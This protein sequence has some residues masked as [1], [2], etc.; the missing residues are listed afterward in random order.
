[1][2][3]R[4][5]RQI[6]G[7]IQGSDKLEK[8]LELS[9]Y[10]FAVMLLE[11][12]ASIEHALMVQYL[13][14]AYS[15]RADHAKAK[16]W[17][18]TLLT[19]AREEMGHL[20]TVQN[21][22]TLLGAG[23]NLDRGDY[24]WDVPFEACPFRLERLSQ[25][26]LACYVYAE[27][28]PG[29]ELKKRFKDVKRD[30]EEHVKQKDRDGR[31]L[32][33]GHVGHVGILYDRVIKILGDRSLV[34]D[35]CFRDSELGQFGW[36]EWGRNYRGNH[37]D[38][39]VD[40]EEDDEEDGEE[41]DVDEEEDDDEREE[42]QD[43]ED[44]PRANLLIRKVATREEALIALAE[45]SEQGEGLVAVKKGLGDT[46]ILRNLGPN[47]PKFK[48]EVTH[49]TRFF[50]IYKELQELDPDEEFSWK[51]PDNPTT[52]VLVHEGSTDVAAGDGQTLIESKRSIRWAA[53]FNLR[54]RMLLTWMSHALVLVRRDPPS[55]SSYLCGQVVHRV[56]G[57]MYNIKAIAEM[58]VQMPLT[59]IAGDPRRAGPPFEMPYRTPLPPRDRDIWEIHRAALAAARNLYEEL[60]DGEPPKVVGPSGKKIAN[61]AIPYLKA[62]M[63]A[64]HDADQWIDGILRGLR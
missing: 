14:A 53:L 63:H 36:D 4:E 26:S 34:P 35:I 31:I 11:I 45:L 58:L 60:R 23:F 64:D 6:V 22:L 48:N 44:G 5:V 55:A 13:Y 52:N 41:E 42:R 54:Y 9:W 24:P 62:L 43:D 21:I 2:Q 15:L 39:E 37:D 18:K 32:S 59:D 17:R 29:D 25:G 56:F 46:E 51:V 16:K 10:E 12:G 40:E 1:M 20:L 8:P 49:F 27:M 7:L 3:T 30:A 50:S 47:I 38:Q 61:P 57:E 28:S 33:D 19:I